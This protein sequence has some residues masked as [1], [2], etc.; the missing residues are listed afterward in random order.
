MTLVAVIYLWPVANLAKSTD[1]TDSQEKLLLQT[2]L[3]VASVEVVG[4]LPILLKVVLIVR[5]EK[6]EFC[7]SD[8]YEPKTCIDVSSRESDADC[9]PV[10]V[11]VADRLGRGLHEVLCV[12]LGNL[13]SL[14]G[15]NL[16]EIAV[17]V[18]KSHSNEV[19]VHVR[20]LLEV[21]A[22]EYAEA[23][24]INLQ[25]RVKTVFHTEIRYRRVRP[26]RLQPHI[27]V[28]LSFHSFKLSKELDVRAEFLEFFEAHAVKQ[29]NRVLSAG[30]PALRIY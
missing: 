17:A 20:G 1:S 12:I 4:N 25:R 27:F 9:H 24:G 6:I 18:E 26:L 22:G 21:V 15:E 29:R 23:A 8:I 30:L 3:P 28:K 14:C 5:V 11:L 16:C 13:R 2:V 7:P 19:H 10:T